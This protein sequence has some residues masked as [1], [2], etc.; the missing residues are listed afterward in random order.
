MYYNGKG[1][2][3]PA[4]LGLINNNVKILILFVSQ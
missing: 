1:K 3:N 2:S 4:S